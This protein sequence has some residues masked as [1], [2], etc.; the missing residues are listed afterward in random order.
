MQKKV[1]ITDAVHPLLIEGLTNLGFHCDYEPSLRLEEVRKRVSDY[2][3]MIINSKILVDRAMLDQAEQLKFV[4]RL[5]SGL[6]IIDLD[7]A[8]EKGVAIFRAPD[9]NCNAVAEHALGMLL[10]LAN[11]FLQGDPQVRQKL[12]QREQN[13]GFEIMGRTISIIGFG[14]T[15]S[16]FAQKL[17]GMGMRILAYDKYKTN[18]TEDF[19]FVEECQMEQ[20][21]E[22]TDILSL[23]LPLTPETK[24]LANL[25]YLKKFKKDLIIINTSRGN[26]IPT[27][28]LIVALTSGKVQGA[29]LDVFENEKPA[30]F[31]IEEDQKFQQLYQFPNTIFTP[32]VAGWTIESKERLASILLKKVENL[33]L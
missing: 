3:G 22:E 18:Y 17:Q 30:T 16:A 24:H 32:H 13:R 1:L 4:G 9:G 28:D 33:Y 27:E 11:K 12:W 31:T 2:E 8:K 7:Y 10:T 26:V 19:P 6:E 5:G 15:G 20:I 21:F 25:D 14:Y 29:C 23:H